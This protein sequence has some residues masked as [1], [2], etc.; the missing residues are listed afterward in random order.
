MRRKKETPASEKHDETAEVKSEE[1]SAPAEEAAAQG[2]AAAP[3]A[4]VTAAEEPVLVCADEQAESIEDRI[5]QLEEKLEAE[6]AQA[7]RVLADFQ[8]YRRRS[9]EQRQEIASRAV[10]SFVAELLPVLD[11]FERALAASKDTQSFESL[12]AGVEMILR[13]LRELLERHGVAPIEAVGH[14]FDPNLHDAVMRVE[15]PDVEDN[16][17]VEEL[18]R[19]YTMDGRVIRPAMVKVATR[20]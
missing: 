12:V 7:L 15:A 11:N 4:A 1:E 9:E 14:P 10:Q 8:N 3:E 17:V 2:E 5:V 16:T 6:R 20:S 13:Q 18:Q 19:G